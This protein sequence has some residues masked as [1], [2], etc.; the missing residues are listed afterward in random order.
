MK[1]TT[2]VHD[3][4]NESLGVPNK[5]DQISEFLYNKTISDLGSGV[6]KFDNKENKY[7]LRFA[8]DLVIADY[9][10]KEIN[11]VINIIE[12]DQVKI[13]VIVELAHTPDYEPAKNK[14]LL[15]KIDKSWE[16]VNLS[17]DI[18]V[19]QKWNTKDIIDLFGKEKTYLSSVFS[20]ELMHSYTTYKE[21]YV[22]LKS[23][24]EYG[25]SKSVKAGIEPFDNLL[26][27]IYYS[28]AVENA[29]RP[30]QV[31]T[32]MKQKGIKKKDFLTFLQ[33]NDV[34]QQLTEIRNLTYEK[35]FNSLLTREPEIRKEFTK[36][37]PN[38]DYSNIS[39]EQI[40]KEFLKMSY[41]HIARTSA[42]MAFS[43]LIN[44]TSPLQMLFA[45]ISGKMQDEDRQKV[46]D[47]LA[48]QFSK[49]LGNPEM[50]YKHEIRHMNIVADK[51]MRKLSKLYD[52]ANTDEINEE[53]SILDWNLHHK[54][55][56]KTKKFSY[57]LSDV[58]EEIERQLKK[59]PK[60]KS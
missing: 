45:Q 17:I 38:E 23:R 31:S 18:A 27:N 2:L 3:I 15:Q 34:Y 37:N 14:Y 55:V 54:L 53:K 59:K 21:P 51:M 40:I 28:H 11:F 19:P 42:K 48:K 49:Y 6:V 43:Q 33:N 4:L 8:G 12:T 47:D 7:D 58:Q 24:S 39:P 50:F 35:F 57:K 41:Y 25:A 46:V 30:S 52:M 29:T 22:S 44:A 1:L 60:K 56:N 36:A 32:E 10:I 5:I 16:I 20:H 9:S 13:P 26:Y